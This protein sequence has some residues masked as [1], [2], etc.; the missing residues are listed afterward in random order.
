V[1]GA[2]VEIGVRPEFARLARTGPGLPVAVRRVEDLGAV[3]VLRATCGGRELAAVVA[4]DQP[5][6]DRVEWLRFDPAAI[7]VYADGWL[8]E[9]E[10]A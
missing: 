7:N 2:Q 3:R 9:G 1:K 8:V 5:I 6:P 10:A 4:E